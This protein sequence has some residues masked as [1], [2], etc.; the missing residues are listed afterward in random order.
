MEIDEKLPFYIDHCCFPF[1]MI[2]VLLLVLL[3]LLNYHLKFA[4]VP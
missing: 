3:V 4:T 1:V 2:V